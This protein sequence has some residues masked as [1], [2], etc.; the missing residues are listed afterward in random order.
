[1]K[2]TFIQMAQIMSVPMGKIVMATARAEVQPEASGEYSEESF[3][4]IVKEV[5]AR[6]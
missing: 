4:A 2:F 1:M 5:E 6:R 3:K